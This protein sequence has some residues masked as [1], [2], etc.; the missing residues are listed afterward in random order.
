MA[1]RVDPMDLLRTTGC[2]TLTFDLRP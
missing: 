2:L 1:S